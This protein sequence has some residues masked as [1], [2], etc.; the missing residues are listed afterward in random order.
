MKKLG[1]L[2]NE[3]AVKAGIPADHPGL[4]QLQALTMDVDDTITTAFDGLMSLEGAKMN[5]KL[6]SHF[7]ANFADGLDKNI[8][9]KAKEYGLSDEVIAEIKA[10]HSTVKRANILLEKATAHIKETASK[11][12]KGDEDTEK[13][14][15]AIKKLTDDISKISKDY[16]LKEKDLKT[17]FESERLMA[18]IEN[19]FNKYKWSDSFPKEVRSDLA[20]LSLNKELNEIGAK[21]VRD[22]KGVMKLVQI[23]NPEL[24]YLDS[25]NQSITFEALAD[26]IMAN[27]KYIAVNDP[28][29]PDPG[30]GKPPVP[31]NDP[32]PPKKSNP[33]SDLVNSSLRIAEEQ[34]KNSNQ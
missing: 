20:K 33:V 16:E 30:Q 10:E 12:K 21:V 31:G 9:E 19:A 27:N 15:E 28:G 11:G 24:D 3:A 7:I 32:V 25:K 1:E 4:K 18:N 5:G 14:K 13:Y 17:G 23:K 8:L 22:E 6:K 26:R 2:L 34:F 29:N